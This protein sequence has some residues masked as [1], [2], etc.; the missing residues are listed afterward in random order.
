V[1]SVTNVL[2]FFFIFVNVYW[3]SECTF[4]ASKLYSQ[5]KNREILS[6]CGSDEK[7]DWCLCRNLNFTI[8][9]QSKLKWNEQWMHISHYCLIRV[10]VCFSGIIREVR[11]IK[12]HF[13]HFF[14]NWIKYNWNLIISLQVALRWVLVFFIFFQNEMNVFNKGYPDVARSCTQRK[15]SVVLHDR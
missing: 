5:A 10:I 3:C 15:H 9:S 7:I 13:G 2:L 8:C 4:N 14:F 12:G 11:R 6:I 1:I